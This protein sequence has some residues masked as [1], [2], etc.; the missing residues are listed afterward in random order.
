[1]ASVHPAIY[2]QA[3]VTRGTTI[4]SIFI[5]SVMINHFPEYMLNFHKESSL[6]VIMP[7]KSLSEIL[8]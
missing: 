5:H 1:M 4:A 3:C 8:I 7:P 2:R 6:K